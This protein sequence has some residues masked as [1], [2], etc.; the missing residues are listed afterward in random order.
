MPAAIETFGLC[1]LVI[2]F[3]QA[4]Y[5]DVVAP[6]IALVMIA[7]PVARDAILGLMFA[8]PL[9]TMTAPVTNPSIPLNQS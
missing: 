4:V 3:L 9:K 1:A 2:P 5:R 6:D 8:R 7:R